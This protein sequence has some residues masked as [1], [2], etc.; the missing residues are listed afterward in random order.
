MKNK[1]D[2][3]RHYARKIFSALIHRSSPGNILF[4][5]MPEARRVAE[6]INDELKNKIGIF[7]AWQNQIKLMRINRYGVI[8][9]K[10]FDFSAA[11]E[12][13]AIFEAALQKKRDEPL[14]WV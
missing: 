13:A 10:P 3:R 11:D 4:N 5:L 12:A 6:D 1:I 7:F 14:G 8:E 2:M 9:G